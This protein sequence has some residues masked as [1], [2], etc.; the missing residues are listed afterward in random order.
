MLSPTFMPIISFS[1]PGRYSHAPARNSNGSRM[2]L[3][4]PD[5]PST[6]NVYSIETTTPILY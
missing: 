1:S 4:R 5:R 3:I 2:T 6:F